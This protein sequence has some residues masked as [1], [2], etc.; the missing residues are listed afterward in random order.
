MGVAV[1]LGGV[2]RVG[3]VTP[4]APVLLPRC[5]TGPSGAGDMRSPEASVD[6]T[7]CSS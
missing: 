2:H 6:P 7:F 4:R 5:S 3:G 1:A